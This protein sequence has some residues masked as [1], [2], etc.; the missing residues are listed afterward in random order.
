MV[1]LNEKLA[2]ARSILEGHL[3][4]LVG[5]NDDI[6]ET[7]LEICEE[8]PLYKYHDT[9]GPMCDSN[10]YINKETEDVSESYKPGYIKGC[11]C[12]LKAKTRNLYEKCIIGKW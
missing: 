10:K 11:G 9:W 5:N 2:Q 1:T 7:R 12:R 6:S 3:N 8:C 4:E